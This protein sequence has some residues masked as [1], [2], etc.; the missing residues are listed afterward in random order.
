MLCLNKPGLAPRAQV[1]F[2][3]FWTEEQAESSR[4]AQVSWDSTWARKQP[5]SMESK[6]R[7]PRSLLF[8][9]HPG[10]R[11]RSTHQGLQQAAG[12]AG[13]F[14]RNFELQP[15]ISAARISHHQTGLFNRSTHS[16]HHHFIIYI[17]FFFRI[18]TIVKLN[19]LLLYIHCYLQ[20]IFTALFKAELAPDCNIFYP[21]SYNLPHP[22]QLP[23]Q[24]FLLQLIMYTKHS[25]SKH[26]TYFRRKRQ[27]TPGHKLLK[28][29]Q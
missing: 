29:L 20:N 4:E 6:R 10:C 2:T 24:T 5:V 3:I 15:L 14:S 8:S 9:S 16:L 28:F 19:N 21:S 26:T 11:A 25:H 13:G 23:E 27:G 22:Q 18:A 1:A 17:Y 7:A 12:R